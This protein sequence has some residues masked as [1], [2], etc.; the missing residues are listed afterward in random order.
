MKR[1]KIQA[2]QKLDKGKSIEDY[3]EDW[4]SDDDLGEE[5]F[6]HQMQVDF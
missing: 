4:D 5:E 1:R 3:Q 2:F 6:K